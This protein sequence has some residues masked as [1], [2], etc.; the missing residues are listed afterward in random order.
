MLQL[1]AA[2]AIA[3]LLRAPTWAPHRPGLANV[4]G[5]LPCRFFFIYFTFIFILLRVL[6]VQE[7]LSD[8]IIN[9]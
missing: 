3:L 7:I 8:L 4:S 2:S 6:C 1:E 5:P 9:R